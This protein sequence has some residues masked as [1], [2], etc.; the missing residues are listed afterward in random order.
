MFFEIQ[1]FIYSQLLGLGIGSRAG[2]MKSNITLATAKEV[3]MRS[4]LLISGDFVVSLDQLKKECQC[5]KFSLI[6]RLLAL[7]NRRQKC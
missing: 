3:P 2:S 7:I 5:V 6:M 4:T 1:R